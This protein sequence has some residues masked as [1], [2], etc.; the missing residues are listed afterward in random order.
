VFSGGRVNFDGA[1]FSGAQVD[2]TVAKF[3]GGTVSFPWTGT[4]PPGV[5]LPKKDDKSQT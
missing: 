5:E 2:F 4:P 3:S 1:V